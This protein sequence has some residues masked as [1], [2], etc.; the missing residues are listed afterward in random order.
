MSDILLSIIVCT[1]NRADEVGDCLGELA[2]QAA[3]FADVEIVVVDNN[4]KDDTRGA[5]GRAASECG[6]PF[7][8]FCET[9]AGSS[10][11]R[12]RGRRESRG[13]VIA[14]IDDDEVARPGWVSGIRN[15]FLAGKSDCLAGKISVEMIG[16]PPEGLTRDLLWILGELD[17]GAEERLIQFPVAPQTGNC[18]MRAEVFDAAGGFNTSFMLYGDD[19]E[20]F[21]RIFALGYTVMYVPTV[22][23]VQRVPAARLSTQA[24]KQKAY[25]WGRGAAIFW[26]LE[27]PTLLQ[28]W[29]K[30]GEY[31]LRAAYVGGRW[32]VGPTL[33]RYFTFW[34]DCGRLRQLVA[35]VR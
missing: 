35:G 11:A 30:V 22:E 3:E 19:T 13:R 20:L 15:H 6:Y 4:S 12:N 32:C 21:R 1:W 2:R 8:Y 18:A 7:R 9:Q 23:I 25:N 5:V 31:A 27:S 14:Y 33:G 29:A 16:T 10:Y 24:L 17:L 26:M 28:R 34:H